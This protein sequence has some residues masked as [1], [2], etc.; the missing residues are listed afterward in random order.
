MRDAEGIIDAAI[1]RH[2]SRVN[3][4]KMSTHARAG[5]EA[6]TEFRVVE[7]FGLYTLVELRPRT[8]R[9]HQIRVHMAALGHPLLGDPTYGPSRKELIHSPL[10]QQ[11]GW[12]PTSGTAR[13][14]VGIDASLPLGSVPAA[15]RCRKIWSVC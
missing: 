9:T 5:R 4:Q 1:G 12:V 2:P 7:R 13:L 11:L 14:G 6:V 8:G 10:A 3:R 15:R